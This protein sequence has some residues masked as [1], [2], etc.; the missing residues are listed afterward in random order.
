MMDS[1]DYEINRK[2]IMI[3]NRIPQFWIFL[4]SQWHIG[5]YEP[6]QSLENTPESQTDNRFIRLYGEIR[7]RN[8]FQ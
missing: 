8:I 3:F 5:T 4:G 1:D 7:T 6:T 2:V